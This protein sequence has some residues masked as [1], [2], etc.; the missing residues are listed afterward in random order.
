MAELV[1]HDLK[2]DYPTRSEPLEILKGIEL[3]L[4]SGDNLAVIRPSGSGKS[5]LLNAILGENLVPTI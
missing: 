5:T 4:T 2:K 3:E 1:I